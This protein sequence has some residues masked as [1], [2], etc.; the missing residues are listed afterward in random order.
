MLLKS[1]GTAGALMYI[2]RNY[3]PDIAP[4]FSEVSNV[5]GLPKGFGFVV[6]FNVALGGFMI[7][8]TGFKVGSMRN[9]FK[10]LAKKD[11]EEEVEFRYS[12]P[13]LYVQGVSKHAKAFNCCQRAHQ[14]ALETFTQ[15]TAFSLMGGLR[16]PATTALSGL[17][18]LYGRKVWGESYMNQEGDPAKRYAQFGSTGIW[19]GLL[20]TLATCSG[21]AISILGIY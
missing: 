20:M 8:A 18:W 12:L 3:L 9:K 4:F 13:N 17:I 14:Q 15:F 16:Y 7:A 2:E 1:F 5:A 19:L 10:E 11:G 21:S 6:A